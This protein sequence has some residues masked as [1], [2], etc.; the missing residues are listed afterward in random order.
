MKIIAI[1]ALSALT[2]FAEEPSTNITAHPGQLLVVGQMDESGVVTPTQKV[3]D[4][5]QPILNVTNPDTR[6]QELLSGLIALATT[7]FGLW[8]RY[9]KIKAT[10]AHVGTIQGVEEIRTGLQQTEK[11]REL[12]AK[13]VEALIRH[14]EATGSSAL[15]Q[16]LIEKHT[17]GTTSKAEIKT[18]LE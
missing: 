10:A 5:L 17:G 14:Q 7:A 12:D 4:V 18:L 15:I 16:K 1:L 11:G 13:V 3:I 9:Q 6:T 2:A 8:M